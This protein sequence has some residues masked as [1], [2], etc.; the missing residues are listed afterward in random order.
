MAVSCTIAIFVPEVRLYLMKRISLCVLAMFGLY[1]SI[2]VLPQYGSIF[3][4]LAL[5][6]DGLKFCADDDMQEDAC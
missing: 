4:A 3:N 5:N 2:L 1:I 6:V